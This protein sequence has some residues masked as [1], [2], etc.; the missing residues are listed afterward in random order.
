MKARSQILTM[1]SGDPEGEPSWVTVMSEGN[2]TGYFGPGSAVWHVNGGIP[3]IVAGV[4]ALLMQTLHPGAMAGVHEHSR[5]ASDPL[6]RLSGTVRWVVTT[7]FGAK[8]TVS[9]ETSRVSRLHN[10]V[11]GDYQPGNPPEETKPYSA[12][13]E[14]LIAWVHV[15]FTDAFLRAHR[16]WGDEIPVEREGES[17]EDRYVRE[18]A[19]A[20]RLMGMTNPPT[21]VAELEQMIEDFRPVLRADDRVR[22]ALT[23]LTKPP[24]PRL[25]RLPYSILIG[26]AI[27]TIDPEYRAMLGLTKPWWPASFLTRVMLTII[28]RTLGTE[29]TSR[30]R[31]QERIERLEKS[32]SY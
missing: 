3:V 12:H 19:E 22:E 29:S 11:K 15:V 5:Y 24:L 14:D 25:A 16:E 4:R 23:F 9:N 21:S 8:D 17:G 18:W 31:A 1:L 28:S 10:R 27:I 13:D 2:D 20:G 7:T 30:K 32:G 26:G 6:G